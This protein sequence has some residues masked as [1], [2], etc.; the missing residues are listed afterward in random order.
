MKEETKSENGKLLGTKTRKKKN[1]ERLKSKADIFVRNETMH[2]IE[3]DG[4]IN[5]TMRKRT[6]T[7]KGFPFNFIYKL[8]LE[9]LN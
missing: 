3:Y 6:P 8:S 2:N 1:L 7:T 5:R 4:V 9:S